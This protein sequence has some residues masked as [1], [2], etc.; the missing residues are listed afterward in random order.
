MA[1]DG[2]RRR[3]HVAAAAAYRALLKDTN[4]LQHRPKIPMAKRGRTVAWSCSD[5]GARFSLLMWLLDH[6]NA[7]AD[8]REG[9]PN[10]QLSVTASPASATQYGSGAKRIVRSHALASECPLHRQLPAM[11]HCGIA[12]DHPANAALVAHM[13]RPAI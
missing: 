13:A 9:R 11:T 1:G 8:Q 12:I 4:S 5:R 10:R 7:S 3:T 2:A 6:S